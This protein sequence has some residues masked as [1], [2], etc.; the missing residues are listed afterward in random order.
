MDERLRDVIASTMRL[1]AAEAKTLSLE[2]SIHTV[3]NWDSLGHIRLVLAL[4]S[5]YQISISDVDAIQLT[6]VERIISFLRQQ[7]VSVA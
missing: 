7:S 1:S 3:R 2:D 6:S 5:S 4:E